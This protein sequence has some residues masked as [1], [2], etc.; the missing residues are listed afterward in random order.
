MNELKFGLYVNLLLNIVMGI[1]LGLTGQ[2]LGGGFT[3]IGFLQGF[4]IS[5]GI[6]FL[7]G[8]W[9]PVMHIG[10]GFAS[11]LGCPKDSLLEYLVSS[12]CI[13]VM[14]ICLI[15]VCCVFAQAG[16]MFLPVFRKLILPFLLVGTIVIEASLWLIIKIVQKF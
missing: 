8:A 9:I 10:K 1:A 11:M 16:A 13:A 15:T 14:M 3:L 2:F 12:L 6:G 7:I 4:I 5:M